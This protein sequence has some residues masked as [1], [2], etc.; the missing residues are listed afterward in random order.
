MTKRNL[1]FGIKNKKI[2][3][4]K[5]KTIDS[6]K[7]KHKPIQSHLIIY[8]WFKKHEL[9]HTKKKHAQCKHHVQIRNHDPEK[10]RIRQSHAHK[11]Y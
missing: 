5:L 2:D 7:K 6:N 3:L 11:S 9:H 1:V 8:V 4:N 10:S